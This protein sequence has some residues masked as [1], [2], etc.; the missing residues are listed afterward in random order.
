MML[1]SL[2]VVL[3]HIGIVWVAAA[4]RPGGRSQNHHSDD[5]NSSDCLHEYPSLPSFAPDP[6]TLSFEPRPR[7]SW[8]RSAVVH[9]AAL[10]RSERACA[11]SLNL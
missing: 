9:S 7:L 11:L 8:Q 1:P 2:R 6:G 4:D 3:L 10:P 5:D